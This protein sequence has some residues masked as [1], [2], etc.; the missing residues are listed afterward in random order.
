MGLRFR[1]SFKLGPMR[2]TLTDKGL[3]N[4]IGAGGVRY[5]KTTRFAQ[6]GRRRLPTASNGNGRAGSS[7]AGRAVVGL[8]VLAL[9]CFGLFA[10]VL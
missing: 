3:T 8:V 5:S 1:K 2:M 7:S 9:A 4:S 10:L 6:D